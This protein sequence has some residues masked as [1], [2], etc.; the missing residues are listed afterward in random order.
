LLGHGRLAC[1]WVREEGLVSRA[2][3]GAW[4]EVRHINDRMHA[5]GE[6]TGT[7]SR[8]RVDGIAILKFVRSTGDSLDLPAPSIG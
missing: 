5:I 3:D 4:R 8:V 6:K 1:G 7:S 2:V